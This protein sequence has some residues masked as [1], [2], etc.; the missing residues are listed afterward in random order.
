M[1]IEN[2]SHCH[3]SKSSKPDLLFCSESYH[4]MS[5][6][7]NIFT[8]FDLKLIATIAW[9]GGIEKQLINGDGIHY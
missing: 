5:K 4:L 7:T 8:Y 1:T 2:F 3:W 9:L 6:I